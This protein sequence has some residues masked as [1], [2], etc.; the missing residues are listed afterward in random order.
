[1]KTKIIPS[2]RDPPIYLYSGTF[3]EQKLKNNTN[4]MTTEKKLH[5]YRCTLIII[6]TFLIVTVLL[7][8]FYFLIQNSEKKEQEQLIENQRPTEKQIEDMNFY[9]KINLEPFVGSEIDSWE[10]EENDCTFGAKIYVSDIPYYIQDILIMTTKSMGYAYARNFHESP[11]YSIEVIMEEQL[12]FYCVMNDL[13]TT[14]I[15]YASIFFP[16]E[17]FEWEY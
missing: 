17:E 15:N 7:V 5:I 9:A 4:K 3:Y 2:A 16:N 11:L 14:C 12:I 6:S 13:E 1:M 10:C 8:L